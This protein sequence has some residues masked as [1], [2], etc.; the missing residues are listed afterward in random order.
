ML[1]AVVCMGGILGVDVQLYV[2]VCVCHISFRNILLMF[3]TPVT[4]LRHKRLSFSLLNRY[5][6][7]GE[8]AKV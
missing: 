4:W 5:K 7:H 1:R 2:C 3:T 8:R 6:Q